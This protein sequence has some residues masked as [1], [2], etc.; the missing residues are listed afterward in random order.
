MNAY[1]GVVYPCR[2]TTRSLL[3]IS[4]HLVAPACVESGV[5]GVAAEGEGRCGHRLPNRVQVEVRQEARALLKPGT[6]NKFRNFKTNTKE[7]RYT[8][9]FDSRVGVENTLWRSYIA[10][11]MLD[12]GCL[13]LRRPTC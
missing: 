6:S 4:A 12:Q 2:H 7:Q 10:A 8:H 3:L 9:M 5:D 13:R 1:V 11:Q